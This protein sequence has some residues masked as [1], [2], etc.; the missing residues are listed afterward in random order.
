MGDEPTVMT[1]EASCLGLQAAM[2]VVGRK[3]SG[4]VLLAL[5][6]GAVR[7]SE[8]E[9]SIAG[10]SGRLLSQRLKDLEDEGLVVR[11]VVP[12]T[13]AHAEYRLSPRGRTLVAAVKPL[14]RWGATAGRR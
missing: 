9:R 12:T 14:A 4:P 7:F 2:E 8:V 1:S 3:W 13:P 6:Q 11:T 5:S 10:I